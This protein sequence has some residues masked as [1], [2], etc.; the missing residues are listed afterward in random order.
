[1]GPVPTSLGAEPHHLHNTIQSLQ[2]DLTG[3]LKLN[4]P[5]K[6]GCSCSMEQ[7]SEVS[8]NSGSSAFCSQ[9]QEYVQGL[10]FYSN[11]KFTMSNIYSDINIISIWSKK[12]WLIMRGEINQLKAMI[13]T[14]TFINK[15]FKNYYSSI[16]KFRKKKERWLNMLC[17]QVKRPKGAS[18]HVNYSVGGK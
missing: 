8:S 13:P 2:K 6:K 17:G 3:V 18:I 10:K 1:M 9:A 14:I 12:V 15:E 4:S 7:Q 5:E 16:H 11:I